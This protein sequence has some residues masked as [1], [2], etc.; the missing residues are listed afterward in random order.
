MRLSTKYLGQLFSQQRYRRISLRAPIRRMFLEPEGDD[1]I[2]K[3]CSLLNSKVMKRNN[4]I[5]VESLRLVEDES[6]KYIGTMTLEKA[7]SIAKKRGGFD[8]VLHNDK[9]EPVVCKIMDYRQ[10]L[11]KRFADE[12]IKK[13]IMQNK[14]YNTRKEKLILQERLKPNIQQHDLKIK[15]EKIEKRL[16]KIQGVRVEMKLKGHFMEQA[17]SVFNTY[18]N[19]ARMILKPVGQ[20]M[21]TN[22][23]DKKDDMSNIPLNEVEMIEEGSEQSDKLWAEDY[24]AMRKFHKNNIY[25]ITQQFELVEKYQEMYKEEKIKDI[26]FSQAELEDLVKEYFNMSRRGHVQSREE[27]QKDFKKIAK[28]EPDTIEVVSTKK[29]KSAAELELGGKGDWRKE[30]KEFEKKYGVG[31]HWG[32]NFKKAASNQSKEISNDSEM[33]IFYDTLKDG[34]RDAKNKDPSDADILHYLEKVTVYNQIL[35]KEVFGEGKKYIG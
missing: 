35:L 26:N 25:R 21:L 2:L 30:R 9:V 23:S 8:V 20:P 31:Y 14:T 10:H 4:Q 13:D 11:Y 32:L 33:E 16:R 7:I 28:E 15:L 22:E 1:D 6:G 34:Y 24:Q 19:M 5:L 18:Q 29:S 27:F 3:I 12:V 17:K